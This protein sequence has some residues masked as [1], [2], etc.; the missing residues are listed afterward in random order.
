MRD[1]FSTSTAPDPRCGFIW[2]NQ[3]ELIV[4]RFEP[5]RW[6]ASEIDGQAREVAGEGCGSRRVNSAGKINSISRSIPKPPA[7]FLQN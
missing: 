1:E 3:Q 4:A 7:G 5:S 2:I 6:E